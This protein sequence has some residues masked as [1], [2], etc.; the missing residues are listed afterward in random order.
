MADRRA[1]G[2]ACAAEQ[3]GAWDRDNRAPN[4]SSGL[5]SWPGVLAGHT[6][7]GIAIAAIQLRR[8]DV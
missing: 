1:E 7:V 2:T 5:R 4:G 6:A 3:M 8:R